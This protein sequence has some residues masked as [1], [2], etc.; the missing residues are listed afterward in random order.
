MEWPEALVYI[1]AFLCL[2]G[3]Y[4]AYRLTGG[5]K[6]EREDWPKKDG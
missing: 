4:I 2:M 5:I 1:T 3:G 6:Q